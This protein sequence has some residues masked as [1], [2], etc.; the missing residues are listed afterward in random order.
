MK[1][2]DVVLNCCNITDDGELGGKHLRY[3]RR[4]GDQE[5]AGDAPESPQPVGYKSDILYISFYHFVY[6]YVNI[7]I[8]FYAYCPFILVQTT[9]YEQIFSFLYLYLMQTQIQY[10]IYVFSCR[11]K[12]NIVS[13]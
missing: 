13:K 12:L 7:T 2:S 3:Y 1:I 8:I 10:C 5:L 4:F 6:E 11:H 9:Q